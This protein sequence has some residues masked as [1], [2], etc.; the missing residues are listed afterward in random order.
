MIKR[1]GGKGKFA[2]ENIH[3]MKNMVEV[4]G[5]LNQAVANLYSSIRPEITGS[6]TLTVR[7]WLET[8]SYGKQYDFG[9]EALEKVRKGIW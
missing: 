9:L 4:P 8:Q 3:S 7:K 1:M 5:E 6:K 2:A